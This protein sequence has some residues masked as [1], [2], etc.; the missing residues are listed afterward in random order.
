MRFRSGELTFTAS[1]V[2][3]S[4]TTSPQTGAQLRAI[5]IQL[6]APKADVHEQLVDTAQLRARGGLLSLTDDDQPDVEWKVRDSGFTYIGSAPWG[7]HHHTW[8]LEE[9]ES[10]ACTRLLLG[11]IE[12]EPYDYR[13]HVAEDGRLRLAARA[14]VTAA[15]LRAIY[16]LS[17]FHAPVDVVRVGINQEPCRMHVEQYVWG[18]RSDS[19]AVV[20]ACAE[21]GDPRVTLEHADPQPLRPPALTESLDELL[22]LLQEKGLL[23]TTERQRVVDAGRERAWE[24]DH[25]ARHVQDPDG[26]PL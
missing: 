21:V 8:Q 26:W 14:S 1:I 4:Q 11:T 13:E 25:A 5:T 15:D 9:I 7:V 2:D 10:I 18:E 12:L 16:N 3:A 6:R 20:L 23:S 24:R 17:A 19:L 22:S